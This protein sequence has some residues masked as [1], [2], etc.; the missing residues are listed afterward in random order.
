MATILVVEDDLPTQITF[1]K[2]LSA[3]GH[4][5]LVAEDG[6]TA[7]DWL[8][9][10]DLVILDLM[11][12]G[13]SGWEVAEVLRRD[14]A[15][16]P[17][18]MVT[19]LGEIEDRLQGFEL[20]AEDYIVKPVD[21][22]ELDARVRVALRRLVLQDEI[23]VGDLVVSPEGQEAFL[24]GVRLDLSQLEFSLLHRLARSL[25]RVFT[26]NELLADVWGPEYFGTDRTVDVRVTRLRQKLGDSSLRPR[27]IETIR[28]IGYRLNSLPTT[29]G[30]RGGAIQGPARETRDSGADARR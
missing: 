19:S 5:V 11:L 20:G 6:H 12:P 21:L 22:H 9:Q 29:G 23:V 30:A 8:W 28:G 25:G 18:L 16:K 3:R 1:Q 24:A 10:A 15:D 14:H 4:E 27:Y 7:L 17:Y 13:M 2:F 26:R